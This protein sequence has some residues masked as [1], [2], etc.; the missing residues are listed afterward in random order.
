MRSEGHGH[1]VGRDHRGSRDHDLAVKL[2]WHA[3]EANH[4]ISYLS[5]TYSFD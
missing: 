5:I 1:T 4:L 3:Q 2:E